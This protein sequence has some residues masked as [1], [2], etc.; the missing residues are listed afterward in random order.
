MRGSAS[1]KTADEGRA[2]PNSTCD[3]RATA[4]FNLQ[5]SCNSGAGGRTTKLLN[6]LSFTRFR[7]SSR[8]IARGHSLMVNAQCTTSPSGSYCRANGVR[9]CW[10]HRRWN[11]RPRPFAQCGH[12]HDPMGRDRL[13]IKSISNG[14]SAP[15]IGGESNA[16]FEI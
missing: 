9:N 10:V 15:L 7:C 12:R 2:A 3:T 1:R 6:G 13:S 8:S 5:R 16:A 4:L 14:G 11:W